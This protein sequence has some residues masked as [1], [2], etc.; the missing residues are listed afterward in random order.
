MLR[1]AEAAA[2]AGSKTLIAEGLSTMDRMLSHEIHR[3]RTLRNANPNVRPEE[4]ALAESEHRELTAALRNA[5][6]RLDSLRMIWKGPP[7][8][9]E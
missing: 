9:L 4:I 8:L 7:G 2:E 6:L 5:R 1:A 3:L